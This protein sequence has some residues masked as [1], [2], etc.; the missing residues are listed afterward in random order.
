MQDC[1]ASSQIFRKLLQ[2]TQMK[3]ALSKLSLNQLLSQLHV[4]AYVLHQH[5]LR[6]G[7]I[8]SLAH[9]SFLKVIV[10]LARG[11]QRTFGECTDKPC[12]GYTDSLMAPCRTPWMQ[13]VVLPPGRHKL[14][15]ISCRA[16]APQMISSASSMS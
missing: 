15:G 7:M 13:L 11:A 16:S 10:M 2:L 14:S 4:S 1:I 6:T 12:R 8:P 9:I 3:S 5:P